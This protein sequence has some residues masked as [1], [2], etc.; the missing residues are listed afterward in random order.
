M[1][2]QRGSGS[3]Q[4]ASMASPYAAQSE[5]TV[6]QS[7]LNRVES[8]PMDGTPKP[9]GELLQNLHRTPAFKRQ[10]ILMGHIGAMVQDI[11]RV[12][13]TDPLRADRK[14]FEL[15][16]PSLQLIELKHRLEQLFAVELPVTLFFEHV[17]LEML[18]RYL[19]SEVLQLAPGR[20]APGAGQAPAM[21]DESR[22]MEELAQLSDEEA[23]ARLLQRMA[24][25][26]RRLKR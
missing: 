24:E 25:S 19:L 13:L 6:A 17:T 11:R 1:E 15:G 26:A 7:R 20:Q 21:D 18:T 4:F 16:L 12:E 9:A 5:G 22:R 14:V 3:A 10:E 8:S 2:R 23:E